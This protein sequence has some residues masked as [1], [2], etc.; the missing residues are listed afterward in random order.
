MFIM[1]LIKISLL[2]LFIYFIY[3]IFKTFTI[4]NR[5]IKKENERNEHIQEKD[6]TGKVIELDKDEY[7]VE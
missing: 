5:Y 3:R 1:N 7:K 2:F 4:V 6:K